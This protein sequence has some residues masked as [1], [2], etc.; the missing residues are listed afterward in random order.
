MLLQSLALFFLIALLIK[1]INAWIRGWEYD[2]YAPA[3][4]YLI[5]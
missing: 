1:A 3:S 5:V 4:E 2:N